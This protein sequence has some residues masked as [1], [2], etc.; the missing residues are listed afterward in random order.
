MAK[1]CRGTKTISDCARISV[2]LPATG[3]YKHP[4]TSSA[5]SRLMSSGYTLPVIGGYI[6]T[7]SLG[8]R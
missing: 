1:T 5:L 6:K 7:L 4:T 2:K 3:F 8:H